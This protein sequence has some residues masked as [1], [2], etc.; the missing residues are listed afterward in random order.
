LLRFS[1]SSFCA[2]DIT[3]VDCKHYKSCYRSGKGYDNRMTCYKLEVEK[4]EF[5]KVVDVKH[6]LYQLVRQISMYMAIAESIK[7]QYM[8]DWLKP[9]SLRSVDIEKPSFTECCTFIDVMKIFYEYI[10]EKKELIARSRDY[11][12]AMINTVIVVEENEK[13][14]ISSSND[15]NLNKNLRQFSE[16]MGYKFTTDE[17][18]FE[19]KSRRKENE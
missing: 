2:K 3:C 4:A 6:D 8:T 9:E 1:Y 16:N 17:P 18:V 10:N 5:I 14:I 12:S 19:D 13:K 15:K 11:V 7:N